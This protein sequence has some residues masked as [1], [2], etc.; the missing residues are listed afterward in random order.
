MIGLCS[1]D[2][3]LEVELKESGEGDEGEDPPLE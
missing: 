3:E 1:N 2:G